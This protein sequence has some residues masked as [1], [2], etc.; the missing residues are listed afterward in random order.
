V[1]KVPTGTDEKRT[2]ASPNAENVIQLLHTDD[3]IVGIKTGQIGKGN[4]DQIKHPLLRE[5]AKAIMIEG[6]TPDFHA[7]QRHRPNGALKFECSLLLADL[8]PHPTVKPAPH[9]QNLP[10]TEK[11]PDW[12]ETV[13]C[14]KCGKDIPLIKISKAGFDHRPRVALLTIECGEVILSGN[15]QDLL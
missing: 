2:R 15:L 8:V 9:L 7:Y 1:I 3:F 10:G 6:P 12:L 4:I 11:L 14:R 5:V 13:K